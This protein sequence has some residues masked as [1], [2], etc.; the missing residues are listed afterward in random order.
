MVTKKRHIL[1]D[2]IDTIR[3]FAFCKTTVGSA[4]LTSSFE[5]D[6]RLSRR[7]C[8]HIMATEGMKAAFQDVEIGETSTAPEEMYHL[9]KKKKKF[10][11]C[12]I[13]AKTSLSRN[14]P[15]GTQGS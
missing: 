10:S 15:G 8:A 1:L 2:C 13:T 14:I 9:F 12:F 7:Q 11:E 4:L 3:E 6:A 5:L